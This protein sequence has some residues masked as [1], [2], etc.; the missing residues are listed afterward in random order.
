MTEKK[1]PEY[2]FKLK[3]A[4]REPDYNELRILVQ[5]AVKN[6]GT[7]KVPAPAKRFSGNFTATVREYPKNKELPNW[8]RSMVQKKASVEE[9]TKT[10]SEYVLRAPSEE[11]HE[12]ALLAANQIARMEGGPAL[13]Q[14]YVTH[15]FLS[16]LSLK[17][18]E[19]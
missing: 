4:R 13:L 14:R 5:S 6:G 11:I 2:P 12:F 16:K 3:D 15:E 9:L 1:I 18:G 19:K 17:G 8:F 10:L 7:N